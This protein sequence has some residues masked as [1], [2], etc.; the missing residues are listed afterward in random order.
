MSSDNSE[1][2][3][4]MKEDENYNK[5]KIILTKILRLRGIALMCLLENADFG[6]KN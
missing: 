3:N 4:D 2:I 1:E 5:S 6:G